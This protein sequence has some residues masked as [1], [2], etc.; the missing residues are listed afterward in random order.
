[1]KMETEKRKRGRPRIDAHLSEPSASSRRQAVNEKY[2][3]DAVN[4][5]SVAATE[6]SEGS[7][8]WSTD[9]AAHTAKYKAG[10]LE[11]IGRMLEQDHCT[12]EDCIHITNLA[13]AAVKAGCTTREI[14]KAIRAIRLAL[15]ELDTDSDNKVFLER[16]GEAILTLEKMGE[17]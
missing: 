2:L 10:I 15:R 12:Q 4:L 3:F 13:I 17:Q 14:E 11:Q 6:I 8:L 1:M 9:D 16:A 5:I 7:L